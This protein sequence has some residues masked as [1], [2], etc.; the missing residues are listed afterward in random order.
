MA[1]RREYV[2]TEEFLAAL[3]DASKPVP[4]T[5]LGSVA[6][7]QERVNAVWKELGARIGFKWETV[8]PVRDRGESFFTA[9]VSDGK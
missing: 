9:E 7:S 2:M 5:A 6:T 1:L 3:R 4:M 8:L